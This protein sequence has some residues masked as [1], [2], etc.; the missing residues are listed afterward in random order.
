MGD[1][2]P[3]AFVDALKQIQNIALLPCEYA[4]PKAPANQHLDPTLVNVTF[5]A[6]GGA[7]TDAAGE[8]G[9][10]SDADVSSDIKLGKVDSEAACDPT[11][12]GWFYDDN[13]NPTKIRLC[14]VELRHG[15][16]GHGGDEGA[17][18]VR[19]QDHR[20]DSALI[21]AARSEAAN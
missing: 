10:G 21:R 14:K 4:V 1:G 5:T 7:S 11:S 16:L 18:R 3:L 6:G 13:V 12:G 20:P 15:G 17:H 2:R 9:I 19:V 8:G